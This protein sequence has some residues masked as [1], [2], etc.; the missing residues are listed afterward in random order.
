VLRIAGYRVAI[1]T[2]LGVAALVAA[3]ARSEASTGPVALLQVLAAHLALLALAGA[4][5]LVIAVR[6]RLAVLAFA[7]MLAVSGIRF[8]DEW[9]SSQPSTPGAGT[10]R[11]IS[12]NIEIGVESAD[13]IL[14]PVL[15]QSAGVVALQEVTSG[16]AAI[17]E[18]SPEIRGRYP[19]RVV[20]PD[21]TV[22]GMGILSAYPIV[23]SEARIDPR[24]L[25]ARL[26][27]DGEPMNVMNAHP[28]PGTIETGPFGAATG[29]DASVRNQ[30]LKA[31]RR[32]LDDIR[33]DGASTIV[34]ADLNLAP[35]EPGYRLFSAD[36]VDAHREVGFG[37]GWTWR[38]TR[39][40]FLGLGLLRIDYVLTDGSL[41]PIQTWVDCAVV[42]DHCLLGAELARR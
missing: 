16:A 41:R 9:V 8:G 37:S 21:P 17:L 38:P 33:G 19:Y 22:A 40:Q 29:F 31:V 27:V 14:G 20:V 4:V 42:S 2:V 7:A 15:R 28:Y 23:A 12:W 13:E 25:L 10:I 30:R 18:S 3:L 39:L 32:W 1:A 6:T 34:M 26:V 11:V 24:G 36:L 5:A 35:S